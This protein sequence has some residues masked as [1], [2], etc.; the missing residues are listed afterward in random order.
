M[1]IDLSAENPKQY[2]WQ[3]QTENIE[4]FKKT[5]NITS[6]ELNHLNEAIGKY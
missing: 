6:T 4:I 3:L 1:C 5:A 2:R